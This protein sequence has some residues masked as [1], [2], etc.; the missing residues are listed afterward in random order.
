MPDQ[1]LI[2]AQER[3]RA[4]AD[5]SRSLAR[6]VANYGAILQTMVR[7]TAELVG[8]GAIITMLSRDGQWLERLAHYHRDPVRRA[9]G[10]ELLAAPYPADQGPAG[11]VIRT[12]MPVRTATASFPQGLDTKYRDYASRFAIDAY[13]IVPLR[14][15][16]QVL[17]TLG[18]SRRGGPYADHDEEFLQLLADAAALTITTARLHTEAS[19]RLNRLTLLH[20]GEMA[21]AARLGLRQPLDVLLDQVRAGLSVDAATVYRPGA[22]LDRGPARQAVEQRRT[23]VVRDVRTTSDT[24]RSTGSSERFVSTI[25]VPLIAKGEV[26]GVLELFNRTPLDPDVESMQF[27]ETISARAAAAIQTN[28]LMEQLRR[29]RLQP[30][31]IN[32]STREGRG[33]LSP[34]QQTIY[35]MLV[36]GKSNREIAKS[37]HV[38]EHAVKFHIRELFRKLGVRNRVEA[39]T[40]AVHGVHP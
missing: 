20:Q 16:R 33:G 39:A 24:P 26:I 25:A 28:R 34:P 38:S 36:Q 15:D 40:L 4:V 21:A 37:M 10:R 31:G 1:A 22:R 18:V 17:G 8:D 12:G 30:D 2:D 5:L 7:R 14:V 32:L 3:A 6:N 27:L 19:Q 35:R 13:L 11:Q 29:P 23:I 9:A